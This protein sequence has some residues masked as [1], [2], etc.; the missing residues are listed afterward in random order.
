MKGATVL[1]SRMSATNVSADV[2]QHVV[3][4]EDS[5]GG[6]DH[7]WLRH[8]TVTNNFASEF[9]LEIKV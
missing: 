1:P 6:G 9:G 8:R 4:E 7:G 5:G 3:K 2:M